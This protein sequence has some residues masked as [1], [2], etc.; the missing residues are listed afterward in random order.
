MACLELSKRQK[1]T[2]TPIQISGSIKLGAPS[3][4]GASLDSDG[5]VRVCS[6][7]SKGTVAVERK[8]RKSQTRPCDHPLRVD[9]VNDPDG[10]AQSGTMAIIGLKYNDSNHISTMWLTTLLTGTQQ[11]I[12]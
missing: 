2:G 12:L 11:E 5:R 4:V 9:H 3:S 10:S 1:P 8:S 6:N 7:A